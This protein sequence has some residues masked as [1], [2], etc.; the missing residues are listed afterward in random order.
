MSGVG[1]V[2]F[3][4][5]AGNM[6]AN[7]TNSA[8]D[9]FVVGIDGS[10]IERV[11]TR[12]GNVEGKNGYSQYPSIS[13]D[14]NLVAFESYSNTLATA[15]TNNCPDIFVKNRATGDLRRLNAFHDVAAERVE[16][17]PVDQRRWP[18]RR[19]RVAGVTTCR[20]SP[21]RR[22]SGRSTATT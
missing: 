22:R 5:L 21:R 4:C 1:L 2:A 14:G 3:E 6:V 13:A 18:L 17:A 15:D 11:S 12:P 8:T 10:G 7:D 9:V 20:R 19:V 16:P